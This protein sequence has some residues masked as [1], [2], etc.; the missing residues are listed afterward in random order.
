MQEEEL[1]NPNTKK[2]NLKTKEES[3]SISYTLTGIII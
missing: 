2:I 3:S 1:N